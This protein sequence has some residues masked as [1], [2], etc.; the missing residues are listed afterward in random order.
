MFNLIYIAV[1]RSL[2]TKK[3]IVSLVSALLQ[4]VENILLDF[5]AKTS[6][7][8]DVIYYESKAKAGEKLIDDIFG[9]RRNSSISFRVSNV[10]S[11]KRLQKGLNIS[12]LISFES[13]Q[14]LFQRWL[15]LS[16]LNIN[17]TIKKSHGQ[18][19]YLCLL[20]SV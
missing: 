8:I 7:K 5:F 4:A 11:F 6:A 9:V 10:W 13:S 15:K 16:Y 12:S 1:P 18:W 3:G 20:V 14:I 2:A 19:S 17:P